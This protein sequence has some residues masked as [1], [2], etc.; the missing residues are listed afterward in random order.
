MVA[1]PRVLSEGDHLPWLLSA[2]WMIISVG[3]NSPKLGNYA[4]VSRKGDNQALRSMAATRRTISCSTP[5]HVYRHEPFTHPQIIEKGSNRHFTNPALATSSSLSLRYASRV[6]RCFL[7]RRLLRNS[8]TLSAKHES[9]KQ[10]KV[11]H[12]FSPPSSAN[13][14]FSCLALQ[15]LNINMNDDPLP[16]QA[17]SGFSKPSSCPLKE[18]TGFASEVRRSYHRRGFTLLGSVYSTLEFVIL[19]AL[20]FRL[21]EHGHLSIS[22]ERIMGIPVCIT[23]ILAFIYVQ[24]YYFL[25]ILSRFISSQCPVLSSTLPCNLV[26]VLLSFSTSR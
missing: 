2:L 25:Y 4:D 21:K 16:V 3:L 14:R 12:R 1:P 19:M 11:I 10:R 6:G 26:P 17:L 15:R 9:Q 13:V 23:C 8:Q 20:C 18:Q 7:H 5:C 24:K 22:F